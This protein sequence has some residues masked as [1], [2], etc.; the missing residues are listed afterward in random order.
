MQQMDKVTA[1][2]T[3]TQEWVPLKTWTLRITGVAFQPFTHLCVIDNSAQEP[4]WKK[5]PE[6]IFTEGQD[7]GLTSG[8]IS[9][10]FNLWCVMLPC[11]AM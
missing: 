11:Y 4:A 5:K 6:K 10:L 1:A 7:S 8:N 3:P 9:D 2:G